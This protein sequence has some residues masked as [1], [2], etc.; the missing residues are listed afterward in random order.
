MPNLTVQTYALPRLKQVCLGEDPTG[1]T[2]TVGWEG[3]GGFRV[4]EVGPSMFDAGRIGTAQRLIRAE[5]RR[6]RYGWE[7]EG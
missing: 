2:E 1:I 5:L 7:V 4:L 3:G 6:Y